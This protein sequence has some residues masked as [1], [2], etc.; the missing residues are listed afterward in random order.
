MT[1]K[2]LVAVRVSGIEFETLWENHQYYAILDG[3]IIA[4]SNN[5]Q[6]L[7]RKLHRVIS[8]WKWWKTRQLKLL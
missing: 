6:N 1:G 8:Y 3:E 2:G 5:S 4:K 7:C